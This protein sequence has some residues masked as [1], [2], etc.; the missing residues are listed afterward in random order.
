[1]LWEIEKVTGVQRVLRHCGAADL[2]RVFQPIITEDFDRL[3]CFVLFATVVQKTLGLALRYLSKQQRA[4]TVFSGV[5]LN[6][7]V[8][9]S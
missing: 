5:G 7:G 9:E 3:S 4:P 8:L 1:M 6:S 2:P